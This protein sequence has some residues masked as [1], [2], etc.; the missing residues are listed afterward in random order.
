MSSETPQ[1]KNSYL[2]F[3]GCTMNATGVAYGES[4]LT[5]FRLLGLPIEELADW[6][7]CGAP[8]SISLY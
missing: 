2:Y 1:I 4:V 5:L 7:C 8:S 3:P 6:N